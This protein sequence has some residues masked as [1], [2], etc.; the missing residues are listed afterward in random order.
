MKERSKVF[1]TFTL[2]FPR[3]SYYPTI[4]YGFYCFRPIMIGYM[5]AI[6]VI[7]AATVW[8]CNLWLSFQLHYRQLNYQAFTDCCHFTQNL[9]YSTLSLASSR[10]FL[11]SWIFRRS[12]Y[13]PCWRY[14]QGK[15]QEK[16]ASQYHRPEQTGPD[17]TD[18]IF[19]IPSF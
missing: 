19:V 18:T 7:G 8:V 3:G 1:L 12:T 11:G 2:V 6:T 13:Y 16:S 14:L 17:E 10:L 15:L 4:F 9:S 5:A